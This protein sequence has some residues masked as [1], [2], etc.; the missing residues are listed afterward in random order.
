METH[1]LTTKR[2][3]LCATPAYQR[4]TFLGNVCQT[5]AF[6]QDLVLSNKLPGQEESM[7]LN[8]LLEASIC[9]VHSLASL[10]LVWNPCAEVGRQ[11]DG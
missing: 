6:R 11:R 10:Q 7:A 5:A 1:T 2:H 8:L 3:V 9:L 4:T